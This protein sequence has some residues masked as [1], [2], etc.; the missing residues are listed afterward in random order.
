MEILLF[1]HE[2][3]TTPYLVFY[4][5]NVPYGARVLEPQVGVLLVGQG[6]PPEVVVNAKDKQPGKANEW[7]QEDERKQYNELH[8]ASIL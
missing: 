7:Q 1:R 3:K 6:P 5:S 2:I 8:Q 4:M